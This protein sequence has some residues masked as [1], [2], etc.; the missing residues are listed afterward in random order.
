[1]RGSPPPMSLH[2]VCVCPCVS[3]YRCGYLREGAAWGQGA[4]TP[5][6]GANSYP[7]NSTSRGHPS[8]PFPS[9]S[10]CWLPF[11]ALCSECLHKR[12][13]LFSEPR[14]L[15]LLGESWCLEGPGIPPGQPLQGFFGTPRCGVGVDGGR[16]LGCD[17]E[18]GSSGLQS[19]PSTSEA[20]RGI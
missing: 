3:I 9:I 13:C 8:T 6:A 18:A 16:V 20:S 11:I 15:S 4:F 19:S 1:M 5:A 2:H 10:G 17:A 12:H 7:S 14:R